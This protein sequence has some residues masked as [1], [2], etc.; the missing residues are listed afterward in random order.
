MDGGK[1][2]H[3]RSLQQL[4]RGSSDRQHPK[5]SNCSPARMDPDVNPQ[6]EKQHR[7]STR[8][9]SQVPP[10]DESEGPPASFK[11]LCPAKP[12]PSFLEI[13]ATQWRP[14][15]SLPY[16]Q[17]ARGGKGKRHFSPEHQPQECFG[18]FECI[19]NNIQVQTQIAQAQ[20]SLLEDM[21][22][23]MNVLLSRQERQSHE[24]A[25]QSEQRAQKGSV[26]S[27]RPLS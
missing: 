22:E 6:D 21:R 1:P 12:S 9:S 25:G 15:P 26:S 19:H 18:L 5:G 7:K 16:T 20:L 13:P 17:T 23:T 11:P 27:P 2:S 10:G 3:R 24:S 8:R 14:S 4:P